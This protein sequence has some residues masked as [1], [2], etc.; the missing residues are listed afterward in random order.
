VL[1]ERF[2]YLGTG[3]IAG[4]QKQHSR[5][6][7]EESLVIAW[8]WLEAQPWMEQPAGCPK[9]VRT[10]RQVEAIVSVATVGRAAAR[11]HEAR[12]SEAAEMVRDQ[13]LLLPHQSAQLAHL[14]IAV[15]ELRQQP[16]SERV[17]GETEK[18]GRG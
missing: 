18:G 12:C 1:H 11:L 9:Q 16:P 10:V 3:A 6:L 4:T 13:I 5:C 17:A 15:C 2:G 14:A 8:W 7:S